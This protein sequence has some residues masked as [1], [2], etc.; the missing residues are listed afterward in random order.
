MPPRRDDV[1]SDLEDSD[2]GS[3]FNADEEDGAR[4][5]PSSGGAKAKPVA[6]GKPKRGR[7][8]AFVD[9]AA[10]EDAEEEVRTRFC[11][12]LASLRMVADCMDAHEHRIR[13]RRHTA[14]A[15]CMH[16][17]LVSCAQEEQRAGGSKK[18]KKR[19]VF[20]DDIADV[21]DDDD[22]EEHDVR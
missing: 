6:K 18:A 3:D 21:D 13:R 16:A 5:G 1:D 9:D 2:A 20:I 14:C 17:R 11:A 22:E 4:A 7:G 12:E 10:E 19:N 15:A 8:S